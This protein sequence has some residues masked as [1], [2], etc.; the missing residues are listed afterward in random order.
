MNGIRMLTLTAVLA[1]GVQVAAAQVSR[2]VNGTVTRIDEPAEKITIR[3]GPMKEFG[4]DDGHTMVFRAAEPAMLKQVKAGDRVKFD[5]ERVN[6][7]FTVTKIEK[8]R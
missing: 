6:G 8:A 7:Q 2:G 4:M 3:S 5:V 1:A